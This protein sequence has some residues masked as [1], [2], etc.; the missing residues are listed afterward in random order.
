MNSKQDKSKEIY[1]WTHD[2]QT[3]ETKTKKES[4]AAREKATQHVQEILIKL[5][6]FLI[7]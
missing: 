1:T 6:R 3:I 7:R 2:D 4:K 5:S